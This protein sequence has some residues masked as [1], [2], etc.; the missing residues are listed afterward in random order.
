M[1]ALTI[2]A[3]T[4][5]LNVAAWEERSVVNG[6]G[7]RFVLWMQGCPF[8][9]PGCFNQDFLPFIE[10]YRM[11]VEEVAALICQVPDIEGVTYSGGEPMV[12]AKGLYYLSQFL[13]AEGL[14]IVCYSGYTLEELRATHNPWVH[15][16]LGCVD[17]LIDGRYEEAQRANLPWRGSRNQQVHFLT[18]V[19][20]HLES[21][22]N[23]PHSEMEF[24]VGKESFVSTGI[25]SERFL[26]RL[27]DVLKEGIDDAVP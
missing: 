22:V 15:S 17:I 8:R 23:R 4:V 14:T 27:E 16:L 7:E 20:R 10:R 26:Q 12:Q 25:F 2:E 9:C 1:G 19:Y 3:Q 11:S 24:I 5:S 6:P 13:R 21:Q 18:D